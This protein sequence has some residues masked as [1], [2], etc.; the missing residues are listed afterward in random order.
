[1]RFFVAI[2]ISVEALGNHFVPYQQVFA[3]GDLDFK[4]TR[5]I[6]KS[7]CPFSNEPDLTRMYNIRSFESDPKIHSNKLT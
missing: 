6:L 4:L 7:F 2:N 1:M 3:L 5:P